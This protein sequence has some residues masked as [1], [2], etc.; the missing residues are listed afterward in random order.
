MQLRVDDVIG[1]IVNDVMVLLYWDIDCHIVNKV[2]SGEGAPQCHPRCFRLLK[3]ERCA[4]VEGVVQTVIDDN[5][6]FCIRRRFYL[7][8]FFRCVHVRHLLTVAS[9]QIIACRRR[10]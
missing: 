8:D 4:V 9:M 5:K 2:S 10:Q 1:V 3:K 6:V 7:S